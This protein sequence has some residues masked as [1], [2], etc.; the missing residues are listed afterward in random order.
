MASTHSSKCKACGTR[1]SASAGFC[2]RCKS[3]KH[4]GYKRIKKEN[5]ILEQAGGSWWIWNSR[6]DVLVAGK[7]TAADAVIALAAGTEEDDAEEDQEDESLHS[8]SHATK[9]SSGDL[10]REIAC[11][12]GPGPKPKDPREISF[13]PRCFVEGESHWEYIV[14]PR[15]GSTSYPKRFRNRPDAE[16]RA[17]RTG[18]SV[19]EERVT[20]LKRIRWK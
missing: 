7:P 4:H 20:P 12:V 16:A 17:R 8:M 6:G 13:D 3:Q 19:I 15:S 5:L 1:T 2:Q 18:G 9:K 14:M 11:T 10:E